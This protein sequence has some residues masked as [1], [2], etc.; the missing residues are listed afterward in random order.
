MATNSLQLN[1]SSPVAGL[2]TSTYN[3]LVAGQYTVNVQSTLP[4][5]Q[6]T[7]NNSSVV[8]S[9]ASALQIVINQ[10]GS[11]I[12]TVGGAAPAV[13][14]TQ[15]SLGATAHLSCAVNDVITVVLSSANAIDG[16]P[17]SVKSTI[18]LYQGE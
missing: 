7:F 8:P 6:G 2:G 4:F 9:V 1:T 16:I 12:V 14:P 5:E 15:P 3:V 17:N 13:T 10:N 18:N 11:P